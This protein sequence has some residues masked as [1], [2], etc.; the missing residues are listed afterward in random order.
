LP[1]VVDDLH[2]EFKRRNG[3]EEHGRQKD[4][5]TAMPDVV[6][7]ELDEK[8]TRGEDGYDQDQGTHDQIEHESRVVAQESVRHDGTL[9][10]CQ[11]AFQALWESVDKR[12]GKAS[13]MKDY[14]D[15]QKKII[16][17]YYDN[18][19]DID[20]RRLSEVASDLYLATG[21]KTERLWKQASEIMTRL[22]VP[23]S[24]IAHV[25]KAANPAILAEVVNDIQKGLIRPAEKPKPASPDSQAS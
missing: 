6:S 24:R 15:Y 11:R 20:F 10:R 16:K 17:R 14:S 13:R 18:R 12:A 1:A 7:L 4:L 5:Q 2:V 8:Y 22:N 3:E 23:P 25:L 21:K 9:S 19:D